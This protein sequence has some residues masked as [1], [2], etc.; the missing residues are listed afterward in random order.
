MDA[1]VIVLPGSAA[2]VLGGGIPLGI[3][4]LLLLVPPA[5]HLTKAVSPKDTS[6]VAVREDALTTL[7]SIIMLQT[8]F[9]IL[10]VDFPLFP[11]RFA[12]TLVRGHR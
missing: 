9:S 5:M 4:Y 2:A 6:A 7:R 10:A 1:C 11:R 3:M 12:K 8:I